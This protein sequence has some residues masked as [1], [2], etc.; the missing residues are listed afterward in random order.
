M[1]PLET[2]TYFNVKASLQPAASHNVKTKRAWSQQLA[3]FFLATVS[4]ERW[5]LAYNSYLTLLSTHLTIF[6][7][8]ANPVLSP[9]IFNASFLM[10][11]DGLPIMV[12]VFLPTFSCFGLVGLFLCGGGLFLLNCLRLSSLFSGF[13]G[14]GFLDSLST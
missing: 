1:L 14:T 7:A 11:L 12:R 9:T 4:G 2:C 3:R 8:A 10:Y 5:K 6:F 13:L